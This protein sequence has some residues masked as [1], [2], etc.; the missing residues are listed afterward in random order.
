MAINPKL[1]KEFRSQSMTDKCAFIDENLRYASDKAIADH[2]EA[3]ILD[4]LDGLD[5]PSMIADWLQKKG[6]F[7]FPAIFSPVNIQLLQQ[8]EIT[9]KDVLRW[10]KKNQGYIIRTAISDLM[11]KKR[12]QPK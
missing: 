10:C 12:F 9:E 7:T 11:I 8:E 5:N 4:I 3:Y 2:V 1:I 6:Y